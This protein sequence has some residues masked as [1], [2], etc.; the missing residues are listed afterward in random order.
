MPV[1]SAVTGVGEQLAADLDVIDHAVR[2]RHPAPFLNTTEAKWNARITELR[3]SL[4]NASPDQAL[5]QITS[6]IGLLD[7]HSYLVGPSGNSFPIATYRFADGLFVTRAVDP[8]L[9]GF[10][11]DA[12]DGT[13]IATVEA[14]LRPLIAADNESGKLDALGVSGVDPEAERRTGSPNELHGLGIISDPTSAA[15]TLT[16]PDGSRRIVTLAAV[17]GGPLNDELRVSGGLLGDK[18]DA[19]ARRDL[20][21]WTRLDPKHKAF[22]F[23]VNDMHEDGV[24]DA[25]GAMQQALTDGS[26]TRVILDL[27]YAR[28]GST[29]AM[30]GLLAALAA[31]R[32]INRPGGLVVLI[33]REDVS[34]STA[35]IAELDRQTMAV[36]VG[37]PT[38]ARA[39]NGLDPQTIA[40]PAS[41]W[42]LVIPTYRLGTGDPRTEI[43]PE[44]AVPLKAAEFFAGRD[45][46][47]DAA[48]AYRP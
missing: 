8:A 12:I 34:A 3:A 32:E 22:I 23:S 17:P 20:V 35:F 37:E 41:G 2:T 13:P 25:I 19:V 5:V 4:P 43:A 1:A 47:L 44:I 21:V 14:R 6:L 39:D 11:I 33:G 45:P 15:F 40:L 46:A 36:F 7:T 24:P 27:R 29:S 30:D 48:L 10:R 18:P 42:A 38:P 26:A 9:L 31:N 28:G 16:G